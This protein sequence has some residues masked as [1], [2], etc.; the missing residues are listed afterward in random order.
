MVSDQNGRRAEENVVSLIGIKMQGENTERVAI[1]S[2][3]QLLTDTESIDFLGSGGARE[4]YGGRGASAAKVP[5][6]SVVKEF[7]QTSIVLARKTN[8]KG[9]G[10]YESADSA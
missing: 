3:L 6:V 1:R 4:K 10:Y 7:Q 5:T 2:E 9:H 8:R